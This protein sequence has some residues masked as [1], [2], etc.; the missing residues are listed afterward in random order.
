MMMPSM[1]RATEH[2]TARTHIFLRDFCWDRRNEEP[3]SERLLPAEGAATHLVVG[4][5]LELLRPSLHVTFSVFHICLDAIC[6][7]RAEW[8]S[9]AR[10]REA[11]NRQKQVQ[12]PTRPEQEPGAGSVL[13]EGH[14]TLT[15]KPTSAFSRSALKQPHRVAGTFWKFMVFS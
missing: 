7:S 2:T 5:P 9:W 8:V 3:M 6:R 15:L 12:P 14:L 13:S 4:R 1:S 11:N 10:R